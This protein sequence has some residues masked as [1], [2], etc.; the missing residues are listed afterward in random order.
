MRHTKSSYVLLAM[1]TSIAMRLAR[2][3]HRVAHG[4]V[5]SNGRSR[6]ERI[7]LYERGRAPS[8]FFFFLSGGSLATFAIRGYAPDLLKYLQENSLLCHQQAGFLPSQSRD[9]NSVV[10]F[11]TQM[12]DSIG[13]RRQERGGLLRLK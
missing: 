11:N 13:Q 5:A 2:V 4:L 6:S 7:P 10:F 8:Y 12:A 1:L 9:N 3:D